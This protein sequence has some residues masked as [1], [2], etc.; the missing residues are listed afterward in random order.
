[1][2]CVF[3]TPPMRTLAMQ[4]SWK[5]FGSAQASMHKVLIV[6]AGGVG[7]VVAYKCA[8]RPQLYT[9]IRLASRRKASAEAIARDIKAAL[10]I[11]IETL[12]LDA[13]DTT[14]VAAHLREKPVDALL[15]MALPYQD[16]SLMEACLHT[17]TH[18]IDT[19]CYEPLNEQRFGYAEQWAYHKKYQKAGLRALLGCGFDPG[20]TNVYTAYACKHYI[21]ELHTIDI[22]DCNNGDHGHPF[23]TNFNAE[24]NIREITQP[25]KYYEKGR[26]KCLAPHSLHRD[27]PYPGIGKRR[28]YLLYHEELESLV[29]HFPSLK[30]ARFWMTF[31]DQYLHYLQVLQDTGL[32]SIRPVQFQGQSIVPLQFLSAVLPDSSQLGTNY[33]GETSIGCHLGGVKN[34]TS[35]HWYLYNHCAHADAYQETGTQAIAYTTGAAAALGAE[36]LL[37]RTWDRGP[38][39]FNVEQFNPDPFMEALADY[40]LPYHVQEKEAPFDD[41]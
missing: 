40:G 14:A 4:G 37:N 10:G 2:G 29:R 11:D 9:H 13:A 30:R 33:T 12:Q 34:G 38:G 16:L 3:M 17:H 24:I 19:A 31:S 1:M 27:I 15:H 39:V 36:L 23:A 8:Q 32:C 28:S 22:V 25:A 41:G 7:R 6:G 18:Y 20:V 26:W 5:R 35:V 21:D